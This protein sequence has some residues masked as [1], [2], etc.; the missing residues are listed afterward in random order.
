MEM[1]FRNRAIDKIFKR[2]HRYEIPDYQREEVWPIENK[3]KLIDSILKGWRLPKFH[4]LK[5]SSTDYE[6]VDGQQRLA[7]IFEFL[8]GDLELDDDAAARF[9][10]STYDELDEEHSDNFDDYEIDFDEISDATEDE[11]QEFFQ[12]LQLGMRLNSAE[13]LNAVPGK[14]TN[15][16]RSKAKHKFFKNKVRVKNKRYAH[17][18]ILAKATAI[19]IEGMGAGL[20]VNDLTETFESNAGFSPNSQNAKR[21]GQALDFLNAS[22][23]DDALITRTRSLTQSIITLACRLVASGIDTSHG[24]QFNRFT[25]HFMEELVKQVEL[26]HEA[27]DEDYLAFQKTVNANVKSAVNTRHQILLRKLFQFDP[28]FAEK[29]DAATIAASGTSVAI[30]NLGREIG[31]LIKDINE[32]YS[33][34]HGGDL[35]KMSNKTVPALNRISK[36]IDG[37]PSY[38]EF[39]KSLYFLLWEGPGA[40]LEDKPVSFKDVNDLRTS[41]EHD[42]DHGKEGKVKAKKKKLAS[43]FEKFAGIKSPSAAAPERF[44]VVQ[45]KVLSDVKTDLKGL[46]AALAAESGS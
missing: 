15:F 3:R 41:L 29:L 37:F 20:R 18:D 4:F 35:F 28:S 12:R 33:A 5:T 10:G 45:L 40:K 11:I 19:E 8:E 21:I 17:F 46:K 34:H 27:T 39:V 30:Q 9:G 25:H 43:T 24:A 6:V 26:G 7:T 38:S 42:V 36:P 44:P 1:E 32:L 14:L 22:L 16:C 13:R 23:D 31:A 2:R